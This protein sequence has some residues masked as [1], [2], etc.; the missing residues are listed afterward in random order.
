MVL[1]EMP[2]R[3]YTILSYFSRVALVLCIALFVL[4][5]PETSF[6][7]IENL[8]AEGYSS[9][10]TIN[11]PANAYGAPDGNTAYSN[12][13]FWGWLLH[14]WTFTMGDTGNSNE[15]FQSAEFYFTHYVSGG[16]SD[17]L[18]DIEYSPDNGNNW[19]Q[20]QRYD[21]TNP[22]PA[23]LATEGPFPAPAITNWTDVDNAQ[24][25][26][27][28]KGRV[29]FP[30]ILQWYVD[31]VELR[32]QYQISIKLTLTGTGIAPATVNAGDQ[33]VGMERIVLDP[34]TDTITVNSITVTRT[35]TAQPSDVGTVSLYD[36]S[37]SI[38]GS[39]DAGDVE[40]PG[41]S[42]TF[43]GSTVTLTPTTPITLTGAQETYYIVY[44]ISAS[45]V[46]GRTVGAQ[47]NSDTDID[48]NAD[49]VLP[50]GG[51]FPEPPVEDN[52]T[53]QGG[54]TPK[55]LTVTGTGI[56]PP[57]VNNGQQ[58]VG[59][60]R[61]VL[62]PNGEAMNVYGLTVTL[63]GSALSFDVGTV[64]LYD[65]SGTTPGSFDAGDAE[66]P[67]AT[68]TFVGNTV[69]LNP[70]TAISLSGSSQTY[71][72]V[73]DIDNNAIDGRTVGGQINSGDD[74]NTDA[75]VN[76]V[77]GGGGFPEPFVEDNAAINGVT[78]AMTVYGQRN[79]QD[80]RYR[81]W[82]GTSWSGENSAP[83][84]GGEIRWVVQRSCPF[85]DE[86]I[87]G[88]L[89]DN[90]HLNLEVWD[91]TS[92]GTPLEVTTSIGATNSAYR[93]FD[94][95]YEHISG[96]A[97]VVYQ[98]GGNDPEYRVW[99]GNS[100]SGA[101]VIDLPTGG[102]PVWIKMVPDAGASDE[103]ILMTL[104]TADTVTAAVWDGSSWGNTISLETS[105][106]SYQYEGIAAAYEYAIGRAMAAWT[107]NTSNVVQYRFWDGNS[108]STESEVSTTSTGA[109]WLRLASDASS[110]RIVLGALCD[111][112]IVEVN[113]WDGTGWGTQ[114]QV[115]SSAEAEVS[116]CFD[117]AW[118]R[119]GDQAIVCWGEGG[120]SNVKYRTYQGGVW[121]TE[122]D[123]PSMGIFSRIEVLQLI[124]NPQTDEIF[125][126]TL[127]NDRDLQLT[128][129]N[130]S[131][132]EPRD[133]V[134]TNMT[135]TTYEPFMLAYPGGLVWPT[136]V[137]MRTFQAHAYEHSVLLE[138]A[139]AHEIDNAGFHLYRS[140]S[141]DG[142]YA[143][144]NDHL[145]PG[146]GYSVKGAHYQYV[147]V[148]VEAG[149]TYYYK[150]EDVDFRGHGS[151]H[152]P[153][154][155][156]PGG[157]RD[158]DGMPDWWEEQ[159]GL[160]PD[161]DDANLDLDGDGLA[162]L[163][164]FLYGLNPL[165]PDTDGDGVPDGDEHGEGDRDDETDGDEDKTDSDGVRII[166][167]DGSGVTVELVTS[168]FEGDSLEV[169]GQ[170]Y[171]RISIPT[172]S[173]GF[174]SE[175]GLP[176]VPVKGVLVEV[177]EKRDFSVAVLE[178]EEGEHSGY[179]L[180]PAPQYQAQ[181]GA[182]GSR[183]LAEQF[184]LDEGSYSA[185]H[186][187]P[188]SP[189]ELGY[190]GYHRDQRV[191]LLRFY[192]IQFNPAAGTVKLH[193]RIRVRVSFHGSAM[194]QLSSQSQMASDPSSF[195]GPTY[196]LSIKET[197]LYRLSYDYLAANAPALLSEP[198][199][200][201]K[202]YNKGREVALRVE[203][204]DFIEFYA[205][206]EDTRYTD[207]NVYWLTAGG[208]A[209][210]RIQEV[211]VDVGDAIIPDSFWST[212]RFERNEDY[213]GDIPGDEDVDRWFYRDYIGGRHPY[214]RQYKLNLKGVADSGDSATLGVCL[215][216]MADLEPHP[217][218]HTRISINDH[219]VEDAVWDGQREYLSEVRFP[220]SYLREGENTITVEALLDT[221]AEWDWILANWFEVGYQRGF[222]ASGE[223]QLEFAYST[224][225][226]YVFQIDGFSSDRIEVLDITES[227]DPK[228]I[229]GLDI[230]GTNPYS[231][232][233]GDSVT[234]GKAY[235]ALAEGKIRTQPEG[236]GRFESR[237]LRRCS[238]GAD[239]IAITYRDFS[240][241]VQPL[242]QHRAG[243]GLREMVVTTEQVYDEFNHGI[244]S[245]HAIKEF[246]RYAYDNWQ[247]PAPQYVLLVGDGTYDYRDY[248][249]QG[250]GNFVPAYLSYTQYAGE[251]PDD[252]WYG[253]VNGEDLIPDLHLGRLPAR[254]AQ[255]V[256]DMV[257]KI[258]SYEASS[259]SE[260][261]WE[262]RVLLVADDDE[263]GFE[264][265]SEAVAGSLS[266]AYFISRKYLKEYTDPSDLNRELID[267]INRGTLLV[268]YAGHGAEDFWADEAILGTWDVD[269]L[270]NGDS[271]PK[272]PLVV[273][274]TCLNGY[275]VEA[276]EGWDSLAEVLMRSGHKGAV[277]VIT[278]T[279][280]TS[281]GEQAVLDGGLF[282]ALFGK[283]KRRLGEATDYGKLNLLASTEGDQEAVGTFM[284]FGDPA[285]EMKVGADAP[286]GQGFVFSGITGSGG[287][288]F[289]ATA[290]YGSYA[291]RHVMVLRTFRDRYLLP[292]ALG[293][294][295][296]DLYY[297]NSPGLAKIIHGKVHLRF[298]GRMGLSPLVGLGLVLTKV[299]LAERWLLLIP[300]AVII[301][302]LLYMELL[303]RRH[304]SVVTKP[305]YPR[306][307]IHISRKLRSGATEFSRNSEN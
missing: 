47:I 37:G 148:D 9:S 80:P 183:Y 136:A 68:G 307:V 300:I 180:Y 214:L 279:G 176:Q 225:G 207:T 114:L 39:F 301:S 90:G 97:I 104:D 96:N 93:G 62:D 101:T 45:A 54:V 205:M 206:G 113:V 255:D 21:G 69:T 219:L 110:N 209:G 258:L 162:N 7:D 282:E 289:I 53:I 59:M 119:S 304:R 140:V 306:R 293:K 177:P 42:G 35:G 149:V 63:T 4:F 14:D 44:D 179:H 292:H 265:M 277:A 224:S 238:N 261:G 239:W 270:E 43:G 155:A 268:N 164:E 144:I 117:V 73:Y 146:Q 118:E 295:L 134:E 166:E 181:G 298:V 284:L 95:A 46:D 275:F 127:T 297:R 231:V 182:G 20:L 174:S 55:T 241:A 27:I 56:A 228:R 246:L 154:W 66:V 299:N 15:V 253:C 77:A 169:G 215:F 58:D 173:H 76:V 250:F 106:Y 184:T 29:G 131:S 49:I 34:G 84:I 170:R 221:G 151:F 28:G 99:D 38:P 138:W 291:E 288:C 31:A 243:Q 175:A 168:R 217:N 124:P 142:H 116:R 254:T 122:Q 112:G 89:D 264:G 13:G 132:W 123:G 280:M 198:S 193:K 226:E 252:H 74:I 197:G 6:A 12:N 259:M 32:V 18:I 50:G 75:D 24:F 163:E 235:V 202:L 276:F 88:V 67:G 87:M 71:Y 216:G 273:A 137:E 233:F 65:D 152:G 91:G 178:S 240:D 16:Y 188:G 167:A 227:L 3:T 102:I 203:E 143:R 287:D 285:M 126:A 64:S 26:V 171:Q 165:E 190:S 260:E 229:L 22:P 103:I 19:Y 236:I 33:N 251:V 98:N 8:Y 70:M 194:A 1:T 125:M 156:T 78:A 109:K 192:P 105:A 141:Y 48:S 211:Q 111:G 186:F 262:K 86:R 79:A 305:A 187:Y 5:L 248:Y 85:R 161:V 100:W 232:T 160:D 157:D 290:A 222:D 263:A 36:D 303:I 286:A 266:P 281:P 245:P 115:E 256:R 296:V 11:N 57:T 150:L 274:M 223:D 242:A 2:R 108:W 72:I 237:N 159:V 283:G 172:Y 200:T 107:T 130:G 61:L 133:E 302:V 212:A 52:A 128:R 145:I 30:D 218:H 82:D 25:R 230:S 121:S 234:S 249:D 51:G 208:S 244:A 210:K 135:Y 269:N 10:L 213:W 17:D 278:S 204:G 271:E 23:G 199:S 191:V 220:Q 257:D 94:I 81:T 247:P 201:I 139:T 40:V 267:E 272:Y 195:D 41:A 153:V 120:S 196:K 294:S 147:D 92:W 185:D 60:V 83:G 158:G 129:W 189:V